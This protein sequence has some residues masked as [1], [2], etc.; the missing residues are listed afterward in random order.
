[1]STTSTEGVVVPVP[2]DL[3]QDALGEGFT[4]VAFGSMAWDV[5]RR[6]TE[7]HGTDP[8]P[9]LLWTP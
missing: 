6:V 7:D 5:F 8:L 4:R 3:L 9:V 2:A 1:M